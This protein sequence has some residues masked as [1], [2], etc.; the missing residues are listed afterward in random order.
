MKYE[1]EQTAPRSFQRR[2]V[3]GEKMFDFL[4][5]NNHGHGEG[6]LSVMLDISS[7]TLSRRRLE[8]KM[9]NGYARL[10]V[11]HPLVCCTLE[12]ETMDEEQSD[13]VTFLRYRQ[14]E[15]A[16]QAQQLIHS[17][18]N[19]VGL[20]NPADLPHYVLNR[21]IGKGDSRRGTM[22]VAFGR[23]EVCV[24]FHV[25]HVVYDPFYGVRAYNDLLRFIAEGRSDKVD[26]SIMTD[27]IDFEEMQ[28][29]LP[30]SLA[31]A[32][33]QQ[34]SPTAEDKEAGITHWQELLADSA[35]KVGL[36]LFVTDPI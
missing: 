11:Q 4:E 31:F 15:T 8:N 21:R 14:P 2:V 13:Q 9:K 30:I 35:E 26:F 16:E 7:T 12:T 1:W 33:E 10:Y 18:I 34:C 25:S 24:T 3:G 36:R 20:E 19:F 6:C 5:R 27:H 28:R 17:H 23:K 29:R 32:Y 22:Y